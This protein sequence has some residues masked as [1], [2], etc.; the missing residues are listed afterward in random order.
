MTLCYNPEEQIPNLRESFLFKDSGADCVKFQK[1]CLHE[2]F[3]SAA[4]ERPYIGPNSWGSTYGEHKQHLEF[5]NSQFV[6]L[7]KFAFQI[8]I[9]FSASAMDMV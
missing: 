2:K 5:S 6:E 1:T 8:G 4:L 9:I 7:Q 3:N